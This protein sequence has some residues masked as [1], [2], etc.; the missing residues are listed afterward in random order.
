MKIITLLENTKPSNSLLEARHGLSF[1]IETDNHKLL[2]DTGPDDS[3][4][5]NATMLGVNLS[6]VEAVVISHGHYDHAGGLRA[7]FQQNDHAPVYLLDGA[8]NKFYSLSR[9]L[10]YR[11]I[12]I[13]PA[14][15]EEFSSRFRFFNH[16]FTLFHH[17]QLYAVRDFGE[18]RP[19]ND[20]LFVD[21]NKERS[22]DDFSHEL[23]MSIEE[24]DSNV[25]FTGCSHQG[26]VNMVR[27]VQE[28]QPALPIR[29]IIGGFHISNTT[30]NR[31]S[32]S[33][34]VVI[35]LSERLKSMN[36][37]KIFTGHCTGIAGIS[38][39]NEILGESLDALYSGK[40]IEL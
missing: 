31:L 6:A 13:D 10:P 35:G 4:I 16:E 9:G 21:K 11:Y 39:L 20:V 3:I 14:L 1:Y 38:V 33:E 26:V 27:T 37:P 2:F 36:I 8:Q 19:H 22:L 24:K 15:F 29:G 32:E 28:A 40:I 17:I 5:K 12:G 30:T 23:V 7:F 18:F 34:D 25:V